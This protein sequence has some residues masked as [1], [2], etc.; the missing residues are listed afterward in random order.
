MKRKRSKRSRLRGRNTCGYGSR[1]KHRGSGH[2][3]GVGMAGTGKRADQ[4]KTSIIN[5]KG[6]FG[7]KGFV[8]KEKMPAINLSDIGERKN[9]LIKKGFI[10]EEKGKI[11]V[12]KCK[13]LGKGEIKEKII[14]RCPVSKSAKEKIEKAGGKI[15]TEDLI[16][17]KKL[18]NKESKK[19]ESADIKKEQ[20]KEK[21]NNKKEK[22]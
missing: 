4:K 16:L 14:V 3:G 1:K 18:I 8:G 10:R 22:N 11:V 13:I 5:L 15:E 7:K 2:R 17:E 20:V 21:V 12:E 6:Y 19:K 9:E